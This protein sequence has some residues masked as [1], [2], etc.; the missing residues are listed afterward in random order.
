MK[1]LSSHF[2]LQVIFEYSSAFPQGPK[3]IVTF[4]LCPSYSGQN[5]LVMVP[6]QSSIVEFVLSPFS[7][8]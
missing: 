6:V 5:N 3:F 4:L 7:N 1:K 8:Y 2:P